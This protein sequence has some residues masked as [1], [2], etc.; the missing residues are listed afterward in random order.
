MQY[1]L[2]VL[3][4]GLVESV[5]ISQSA[6]VGD[7]EE[8][9]IHERTH[10]VGREFLHGDVAA[11]ALFGG[12]GFFIRLSGSGEHTA[13]GDRTTHTFLITDDLEVFW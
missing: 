9:E 3:H 1:L 13:H 7:G 11:H 2:I 12:Q 5:Y 4:A 8:E 6:F 10:M